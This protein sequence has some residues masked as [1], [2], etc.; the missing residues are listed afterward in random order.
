MMK[1]SHSRRKKVVQL[2]QELS[3]KHRWDV[4][5][6]LRFFVERYEP[7]FSARKFCEFLQK[8]DGSGWQ[9][10]MDAAATYA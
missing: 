5:L 1:T 7:Q 10:V 6:A 8:A 9:H 4:K 3:A 2:V